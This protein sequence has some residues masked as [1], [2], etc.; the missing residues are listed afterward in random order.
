MF[1]NKSPIAPLK[2]LIVN[3]ARVVEFVIVTVPHMIVVTLGPDW[4]YKETEVRTGHPE[5]LMLP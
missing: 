3:D 5:R 2:P 1:P 4:Q